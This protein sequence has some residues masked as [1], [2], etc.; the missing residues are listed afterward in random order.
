MSRFL[1]DGEARQL[2]VGE[3]ALGARLALWCC[4]FDDHLGWGLLGQG[5]SDILQLPGLCLML[6]LSLRLVDCHGAALDPGH[7]GG[8]LRHGRLVARRLGMPLP[9]RAAEGLLRVVEHLG[10]VFLPL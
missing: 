6:G 7:L 5:S 2:D 3:R 10:H 1:L 9:Q 4:L 8:T